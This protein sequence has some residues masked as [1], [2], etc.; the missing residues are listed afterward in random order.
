TTSSS[1]NPTSKDAD[2]PSAKRLAKRLYKLDGFNKTDVAKHLGKKDSFSNLVGQEYL[3]NFD[4]R[5]QKLDEALRVFL[6]RV[7]L[8]GE[9]QERERVLAHFSHRFL[10]C[11]PDF[12]LSDDSCHTLICAMMLLNTDHCSQMVSRKMTQEEFID[13]LSSLNDGM[14][15]PRELLKQVYT[16]VCK[17][18][19]ECYIEDGSH[20]LLDESVMTSS[21]AAAPIGANPFLHVP[22]LKLLKEFRRGYVMRKCCMDSDGH[23]TSMGRRG[24]RMYYATIRDTFLFLYKDEHIPKRTDHS[25]LQDHHHSSNAVRLHHAYAEKADDYHKKQHVFRLYTCDSAQF[26]FQTSDASECKAWMTT[27]NLVAA[28]LSS[29]PLPGAVGSQKKFQRP[30]MP[31]SV[32]KLSLPE[33]LKKF[34]QVLSTVSEELAVHKQSEVPKGSKTN[35]I[36]DHEEKQRFLEFE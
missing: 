10:Q 28:T 34:Q 26:L 7:T 22:D 33:Q 1:K 35:V 21:T 2:F 16:S 23:K 9:T 18:P 15:F 8:V 36:S 29:A 27:I 19:F 6:G 30:L 14:D 17:N 4:F 11:N 12:V 5:S 31:C 3:K 24:W 20:L 25:S 32:T 13:N